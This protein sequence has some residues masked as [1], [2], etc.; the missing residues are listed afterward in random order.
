MSST[1]LTEMKLLSANVWN[2]LFHL[3]SAAQ[4]MGPL[5]NCE[6]IREERKHVQ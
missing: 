6:D 5:E 2:K 4:V 3:E 1:E